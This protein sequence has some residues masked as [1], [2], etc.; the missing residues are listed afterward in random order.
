MD[1]DSG[2]HEQAGEIELHP[3]IPTLQQP[4]DVKIPTRKEVRTA[5]A[6]FFALC[7]ALF[8][9][10]WT[11]G[12]IGPLLPTIQKFYDVVFFPSRLLMNSLFYR[13]GSTKCLGYSF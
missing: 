9:L 2:D 3:L 13:S 5:H 10:G 7:W 11:D 8:L 6:Q 4:H 12:S 1:V